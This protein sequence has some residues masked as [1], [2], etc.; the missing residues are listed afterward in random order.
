MT[1]PTATITTKFGNIT[2]EFF[3]TIAPNHV[4]NF[5]DLARKG[6]YNNTTF[7]RVIP[8]FMIQGGCPNTKPGAKGRPGTGGPGY[9]VN[10][11]FNP[12]P[13]SRGVLSAARSSD[14]N[15]AGCQFF[16]VVKDSNFLDNQYTAF[17]RVTS[18]IEVA[19]TIVSQRRDSSD[20]PLERVEMT[21]T[22]NE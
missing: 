17:G 9:H 12:T 8:G 15:S 20:M 4:K 14:P 1:T 3:D 16:I 22:V 13:H 10:A 21:V 11:E 6:F 7:H 2:L 19:D 5:L 18:G